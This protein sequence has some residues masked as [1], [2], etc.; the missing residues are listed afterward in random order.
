MIE[1]GL[2]ELQKS[3]SHA[4]STGLPQYFF[5]DLAVAYYNYPIGL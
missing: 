1:I 5:G 3:C 2:D 4:S